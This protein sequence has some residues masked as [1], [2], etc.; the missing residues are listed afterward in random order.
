MSDTFYNKEDLSSFLYSQYQYCDHSDSNGFTF[1]VSVSGASGGNCWGDYA[2]NF[3]KD[4][5]EIVDDI[6]S[7]SLYKIKDYLDFLNIEYSQSDLERKLYDFAQEIKD[8]EYDTSSESEYY[9]NY[10]NYNK[11]FISIHDILNLVEVPDSQKEEILSVSEEVQSKILINRDK[12]NKYNQLVNVK[13]AID[14]F[15]VSSSNE[16]KQLENNLKRALAEVESIKNKIANIEKTQS[17]KLKSLKDQEK[18]LTDFLGEN[19]I[20]SKNTKKRKY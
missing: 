12:E 2:Q 17:K 7:E 16:K 8:S 10:T 9:G 15:D 5:D 3:R 20:N 1:S 19:Y 18:S 4:S 13:K 6:K 14:G 11:Y